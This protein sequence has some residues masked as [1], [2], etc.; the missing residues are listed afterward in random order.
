[1]SRDWLTARNFQR[2]HEVTSAINTLTMH[3]KLS[4]AGV[5]DAKRAPAAAQA[6]ERLRAFLSELEPVVA[7]LERDRDAPLRGSDPRLNQMAKRFMEQKQ[8]LPA[9]SQLHA[10]SLKR[11][12]SLLDAE[13]DAG[14]RELVSCLSAL[15]SL[16][17]QQAHTDV[18]GILGAL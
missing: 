10:I 1:M 13:D 11:L 2:A 15:R 16:V 5:D 18:V 8:R 6:R 4:M 9:P 3:L 14:R 12:L 17:E 7:D